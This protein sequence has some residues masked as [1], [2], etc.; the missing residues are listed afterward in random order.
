LTAGV[1][2]AR[3]VHLQADER[4]LRDRLR[5]RRGHFAGPA[6]AST[7]LHDLETPEF[8]AVIV[9]ASLAPKVLVGEIRRALH[10]EK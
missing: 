8:E 3:F 6:L 5:T 9:D 4:L 2:D 10:L 7:Q 1:T